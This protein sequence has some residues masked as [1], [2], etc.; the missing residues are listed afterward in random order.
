MTLSEAVSTRDGEKP[1]LMEIAGADGR[2]QAAWAV[3]TG[4]ELRLWHPAVA[5]PMHARYA[6]TDYSDR[7]NVFGLDGLPL[8]PFSL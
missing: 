3:I 6:W 8:E 4:K 1:A 5:H 2:W 7:A